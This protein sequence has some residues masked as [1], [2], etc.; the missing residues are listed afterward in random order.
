LID[1]LNSQH[2]Y[3]GHGLL[4]PID[5]KP[6]DFSKTKAGRECLVLA[7]W[8]DQQANFVAATPVPY[9]ED[10]VPYIAFTPA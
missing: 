9:C 5:W 10:N 7:R 2:D 3:T 6:I 8:N 1:W 4:S